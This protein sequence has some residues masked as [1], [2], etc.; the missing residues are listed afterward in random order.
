[1][2]ILRDIALVEE[3][4]VPALKSAAKIVNAL[5]EC[6]PELRVEA[7]ELLSQLA[8]GELDPYETQ[9]T[10]ALIA[11]IL[12]PNADYNGLPGLDL[13]EAEQTAREEKPLEAAPVLDEMDLQEATF[14]ERLRNLMTERGV[15]QAA[16][17]A[18]IGI[19]Q[20]AISNMLNRACRPQR[21]TVE[22]I[23]AALGVQPDQ[24]WLVG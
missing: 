24:L 10:C 16:L 11:E 20:P 9:A 14:A 7:E 8:S 17:A 5:K 18:K 23:A 4:Q 3:F 13:V 19:G 2:A 15:T 1:M 21:K 22:K 6:D 12:F